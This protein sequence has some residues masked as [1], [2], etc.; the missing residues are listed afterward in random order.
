M[1]LSIPNGS[2]NSSVSNEPPE[3]MQVLVHVQAEVLSPDVARH[4]ANKWLTLH[5]GHLLLVKHPE[6]LL[7]DSLQWRFDV[8]LSV[9]QLDNPGT[10][11]RH[12]IGQIRLAAKSGEIIN[13]ST[14]IEE[15][16]AN[17]NALVAS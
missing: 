5:A 13:S 16:R 17:A 10:A 1:V 8:L 2:S 15:L 14:L 3:L 11:K 4:R 12:Q 6:L 9:P 7:E